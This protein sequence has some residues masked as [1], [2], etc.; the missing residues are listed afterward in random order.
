MTRNRMISPLC[1]IALFLFL[2]LLPTTPGQADTVSGWERLA[3]SA[4]VL[5]V[6][7]DGSIRDRPLEQAEGRPGDL[8]AG[9]EETHFDPDDFPAFGRFVLMMRRGPRP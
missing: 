4:C 2:L 6:L 3:D 5:V 9:L 8:E 7:P 1:L